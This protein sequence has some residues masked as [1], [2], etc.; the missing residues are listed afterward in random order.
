MGSDKFHKL[1]FTNFRHSFGARMVS[2]SDTVCM[3]FRLAPGMQEANFLYYQ[4]S[5]NHKATFSGSISSWYYLTSKEG[6]LPVM[7]EA[8]LSVACMNIL[9]QRIVATTHIIARFV[10]SN[11][12]AVIQC[13]FTLLQGSKKNKK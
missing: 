8:E 2:N 4:G 13:E 5:V 6:L 3:S 9:S 12:K 7:E 10:Q 11:Y 1:I